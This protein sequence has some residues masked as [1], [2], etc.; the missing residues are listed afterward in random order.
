MGFLAL[1]NTSTNSTK[2]GSYSDVVGNYGAVPNSADLV[3]AG[4]GAGI[5]YPE[6]AQS[7]PGQARDFVPGRTYFMNFR[8]TNGEANWIKIQIVWTDV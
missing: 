4:V 6:Y 7:N 1:P 2:S 8:Y 5:N 3:A